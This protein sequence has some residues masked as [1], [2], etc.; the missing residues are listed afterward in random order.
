MKKI[1][2]QAKARCYNYYYLQIIV[3]QTQKPVATG[4]SLLC[5][6]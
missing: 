1:T 3:H 4:F 5:R 6:K 2:Q